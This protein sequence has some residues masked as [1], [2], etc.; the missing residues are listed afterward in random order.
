MFARQ[1]LL[2]HRNV[3]TVAYMNILIVDAIALRV[4]FHPNKQVSIAQPLHSFIDI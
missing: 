2:Y 1:V 4:N 3:Q